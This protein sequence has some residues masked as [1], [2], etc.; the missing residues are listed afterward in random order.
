MLVFFGVSIT[1]LCLLFNP[2]LA[3]IVAL[4]FIFIA[5]CGSRKKCM[6]LI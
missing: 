3:I 5:I 2:L 4:I 6:T 1:L